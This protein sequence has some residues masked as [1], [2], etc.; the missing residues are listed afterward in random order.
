MARGT[1]LLLLAAV[2]GAFVIGALAHRGLVATYPDE[3]DARHLLIVLSNAHEGAEDVF[4]EWYTNTHLPDVIGVEGFRGAQRFELSRAQIGDAGG[5]PFRYLAIY[6]VDAQD[7][8]IPRDA[9]RSGMEGPGTLDL[10]PALDLDR[11]VAWF[12]TPIT[13]LIERQDR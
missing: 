2:A 5:E 13:D 12:F 3:P 1:A 8:R 4:N 11:T 10:T 9:L 6:E 7:V